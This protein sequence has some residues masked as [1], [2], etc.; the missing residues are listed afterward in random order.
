MRRGP[1]RFLVRKKQRSMCLK[2][3]LVAA[4][5]CAALGTLSSRRRASQGPPPMKG[6]SAAEEERPYFERRKNP[7]LLYGTAWKKERT[8][9]LVVEA[10]RAGFAGVDT[11]CQP[12]HYREDLVG[13][14]LRRLE[15]DHHVSRDELW[16]QT[17]FTPLAGQDPRNVPYDSAAPL[18]EQV[19]QSLRTSLEHLGKVDSLVLHSPLRRFEDTLTVWRRFEAAVDR[20]DVTQLGVSNCYDERLFRRL[21]DEARHKPRVLQNRFYADS[22][23]DAGLRAF[24]RQHDITY[25]TF[26]TLTAN[27]HLLQT[28]ATLRAPAARLDATPEQILFAWLIRAGHQPLTGTTSSLHMRQDLQAEHLAAQ[29][30]PHEIDAIAQLFSSSS[31]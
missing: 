31:S 30:Q 4:G 6:G 17:K 14:A 23:Y 16:I 10:V 18:E 15:H 25:Q 19:D 22:G 3:L 27:R 9:E 24:C 21:F 20:G 11:A 7:A 5:S 13:E 8:T 29:L 26:W 2:T 28:S 1:R 12:K